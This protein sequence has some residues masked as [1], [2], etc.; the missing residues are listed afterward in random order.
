M[1]IDV[2]LLLNNPLFKNIE[3]NTILELIDLDHCIIENYIKGTL[4]V[5]D[6]ASCSSIEFVLSGIL[7]IQQITP[8][9]EALTVKMFESN[10]AFGTAL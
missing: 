6:G 7:A 10:D 3:L 4:I 1:H 8:T 9:G 5:Q 2:K